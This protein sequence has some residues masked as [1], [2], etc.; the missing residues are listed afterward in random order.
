MHSGSLM[1][2][3]ALPPHADFYVKCF[4]YNQWFIKSEKILQQGWHCTYMVTFIRVCVTIV[5]A[6]NPLA[7]FCLS[8]MQRACAVLYRHLW[9]VRLL[10][11]IPLIFGKGLL[12]TKCVL[13]LPTTFVWN[14][15]L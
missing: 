11:R 10:Y 8:R 15:S 5:A 2:G 6:V 7:L 4:F 13:I 9:P 12:N 3:N 1:Q 14:I